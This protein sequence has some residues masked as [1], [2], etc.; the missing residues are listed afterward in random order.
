MFTADIIL[1]ILSLVILFLAS[2]FDLKTKEIPDTLSIGLIIIAFIIRVVASFSLGFDYLLFGLLTFG[3]SVILGFAFYYGKFWG[4]GDSK[5]LMGLGMAL[6]NLE[7]F[8]LPLFLVLVLNIIFIGGLYGLIWALVIYVKKRKKINK[9]IKKDLIRLKKV[10][11]GIFSISLLFLIALLLTKNS[12]FQFSLALIGS[13][14]IGLFYLNIF[15][16]N[17]NHIGFLEKY[18]LSKVTEGDWLARDV[19]VKGKVICSSKKACIDNEQIKILKKHNIK[20]VWIKVGI[21]FVPA[22]FIAALITFI[23]YFKGF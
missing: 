7:L 6:G 22:I 21:P 18:P 20:E 10:R 14:I 12:L 3:I 15:I 13:L 5:L 11:V 9:L 1:I 17:V 23:L 8:G 4:G 19:F 16:K 2:L